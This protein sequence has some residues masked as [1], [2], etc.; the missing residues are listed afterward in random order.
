MNK[1][2]E[3]TEYFGLSDSLAVRDLSIQTMIKQYFD[4][5]YA[6]IYVYL[7]NTIFKA[8]AKEQD[9]ELKKKHHKFMCIICE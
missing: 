8:T 1:W 5:I 4:S 3:W 2:E 9:V 6:Y 7:I